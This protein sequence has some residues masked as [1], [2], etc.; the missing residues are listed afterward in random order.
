M[1]PGPEISTGLAAAVLRV[2][3]GQAGAVL[4]ALARAAL[5]D[6][7]DLSRA[8]FHP[9]IHAHVREQAAEAVAAAERRAVTGRILAWYA[10]EASR[11]ESALARRMVHRQT[12]RRLPNSASRR[13]P[14]GQIATSPP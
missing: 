10:E 7:P 1:C 11:V 6:Q 9:L 4:D 8:Q 5:L 12:S 14:D 2:S 3:R 13:P